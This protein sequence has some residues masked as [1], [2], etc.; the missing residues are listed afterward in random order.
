MKKNKINNRLRVDYKQLIKF[1]KFLGFVEQRQKRSDHV[2]YK[3]QSN[4]TIPIP[5]MRGTDP[6]GLLITILKQTDSTRQ[7]L[8]DFL[9]N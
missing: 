3:N 2:I 6:Q 4:K 9:N 5:F 7:D 8:I 1:I